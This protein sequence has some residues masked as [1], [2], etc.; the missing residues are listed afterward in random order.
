MTKQSRKIE[1]SP[2]DAFLSTTVPELKKTVTAKLNGK[3]ADASLSACLCVAIATLWNTCGDATAF[4][5][6]TGALFG[7]NRN[8]KD[9][10]RVFGSFE[11]AID[12]D[13]W[14]VLPV[15]YLSRCI[16]VAE[17]FGRADVQTMARDKGL[18]AAAALA[19]PPKKRDAAPAEAAPAAVAPAYTI[20]GCIA[21]L[22]AFAINGKDPILNNKI[23]EIEYHLGSKTKVA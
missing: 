4:H 23:G 12:K 2:V 5:A 8:A 21:F 18:Q 9:G 15:G 13:S 19:K 16:T 7:I 1:V 3:S 17:N 20:E 10:T 6:A 22:H 14:K 11:S